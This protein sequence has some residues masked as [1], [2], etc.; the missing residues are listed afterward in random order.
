VLGN[1]LSVGLPD[2]RLIEYLVDGLG[3]RV[4][5]KIDG[6]LLQQWVYRDALK[7]V[8]ELDGA[9]NLVVEFV[10]GQKSN[11]PDYVRRDGATYRV[12]S[13]HLGSPRHVI[14]V[15]DSSDVVFSVIY[16]SFGEVSGTGLPWLPAGFAGGMFDSD[17]GLVR[18]GLRDFDPYQGRWTSRDMARFDGGLNLY[19]YSHNDPINFFDQTGMVPTSTAERATACAMCRYVTLVIGKGCEVLKNPVCLF[20]T[21]PCA[22]A[23]S[24]ICG[25]VDVDL[26]FGDMDPGKPSGGP[27]TGSQRTSGTGSGNSGSGGRGGGP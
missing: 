21:I 17:T 1:L 7:P 11:V 6:L 2:G 4:G 25:G 5:K 13:D 3:R 16:S 12:V 15:A 18:F 23:C 22:A 14:N 26:V 20:G 27:N 9:G 24:A 10:Y 19:R 8:A